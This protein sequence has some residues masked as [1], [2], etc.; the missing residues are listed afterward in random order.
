MARSALGTQADVDIVTNL[1]TEDWWLRAL[2]ARDARSAIWQ[3][4]F[5]SHNYEV[6]AFEAFLDVYV[7]TGN[8]TFLAAVEAAWDMLRDHW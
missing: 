5:F 3:R 2:I 7:L 8:A 1:Y 4:T 6:T